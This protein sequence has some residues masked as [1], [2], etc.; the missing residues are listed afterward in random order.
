[1]RADARN[2]GNRPAPGRIG[3]RAPDLAGAAARS[4]HSADAGT[5]AF[6]GSASAFCGS[7]D[8]PVAQFAELGDQFVEPSEARLDRE[9]D[10][11]GKRWL[12]CDVVQRVEHVDPGLMPC[13]ALRDR[14]RILDDLGRDPPVRVLGVADGQLSWIDGA[15]LWSSGRAHTVESSPLDAAN[16]HDRRRREGLR[17]RLGPGSV[18]TGAPRPIS[19]R[20]ARR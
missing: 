9:R 5:T 1:M 6:C 12:V 10:T 15:G 3:N 2:I 19:R 8:E 7:A 11:L 13:G 17:R 20:H 14:G 4:L 18:T 16:R